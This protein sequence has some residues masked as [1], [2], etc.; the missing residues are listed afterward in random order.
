MKYFVKW[1]TQDTHRYTD[2]GTYVS[3][4]KTEYMFKHRKWISV[5]S[6]GLTLLEGIGMQE[7]CVCVD[8]YLRLTT[9]R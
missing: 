4:I 5:L 6:Y 3:I 8:V 7:L 9:V 2:V 1:Y